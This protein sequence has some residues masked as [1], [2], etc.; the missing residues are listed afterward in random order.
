MQMV[1]ESRHDRIEARHDWVDAR[2][3]RM[4]S[5]RLLVETGLGIGELAAYVQVPPRVLRRL[6]TPS[7]RPLRKL[8]PVHARRLMAVD[9]TGLLEALATPVPADP[10]VLLARRLRAGGLPHRALVAAVGGDR[11]TLTGLF[12]GRLGTVLLR[13]EL[14]LWALAAA[15]DL[16]PHWFRNDFD[17]PVSPDVEIEESGAEPL[18]A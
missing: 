15:A 5:R 12:D 4:H 16:L 10:A 6:V 17:D 1:I 2:P 11:T 14:G 13:H 18:A 7:P 8:C 9:L 3:F